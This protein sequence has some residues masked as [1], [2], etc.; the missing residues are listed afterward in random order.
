MSARLP[1]RYTGVPMSDAAL[2]ICEVPAEVAF[3]TFSPVRRALKRALLNPFANYFPAGMLRALLRFGKSELAAANWTDPGGWKSMAISYNGGCAQWADKILVNAGTMP[4]ALRNRKRLGAYLLARLIDSSGA[5]SAHVL[6]LGA[7]PGQIIIEAL[8]QAKT[9][10]H[11]TLVDISSDAF[12]FGR[13][14]AA[15]RGLADRVRYIKA[16][17]RDLSA[18]LDEAPHV[19]KMLGICEYLSDEQIV[20]IARAAAGIMPDGATIVF[21]AISKAHGTDRFFRRVFG[22]HMI[23]RPVAALAGLVAEAGFGGFQVH[24]EPLGV[25]HVVVGRK[26]AAGG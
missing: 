15:E 24:R 25:Y 11:A 3:E 22:L 13:R 12:D 5:D 2:N 19:V 23:H 8:T 14:L 7:G 9:P 1:G 18:F 20:T 6:C 21:N 17:V 10:A 4:M 16:D 26:A